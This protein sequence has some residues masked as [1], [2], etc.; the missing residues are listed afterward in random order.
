MKFKKHWKIFARN[1]FLERREIIIN[2]VFDV[3]F[4]HFESHYETI[5][6]S[7]GSLVNKILLPFDPTFWFSFDSGFDLLLCE[8][9]E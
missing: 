4:Q 9:K 1:I 3:L 8:E 6:N 2:F 7:N 5:T